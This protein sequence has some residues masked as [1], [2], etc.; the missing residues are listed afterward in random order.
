MQAA[1]N[2][3]ASDKMPTAVSA[4]GKVLLAGG[5]LVLDRK[6]TGL[7]FG[8]SARIHVLVSE[9]NAGNL[10]TVRS[11]QFVDAIWVYNY[12]L[13]EGRGVQISQV[14][15]GVDRPASPNRFVE[16]SLT[17]GLT[18]I[19]ALDYGSTKI[20]PLE[21]TILADTDYYSNTPEPS[22]IYPRF[23]FF[24]VPLTSAH[25]TGLGS[26][27]ALVTA[28]TT[29]ILLHFIPT[30]DLC[31]PM[32][33]T[34]IHN[35]AQIVHCAAQKKVGSGFDVAAAVYGACI[36][37]RFSPSV[38]EGVSESDS[39]D[40]AARLHSIVENPKS[41]DVEI[42]R[43]DAILPTGWALFMCDVD[44]GSSTISMVKNVLKWRE[45]NSNIAD[46][47]WEELQQ[48]QEDLVAQLKVANPQGVKQSF[49]KIRHQIRQLSMLSGVPIEPPEQ[50]A[51]LDAINTNVEE[52]I[53]GVV[54][55]A[56]G[57]DAAVLLVRENKSVT[58]KL[59]KF[60]E[61]WSVQKGGKFR[62]LGV[63][64]ESGG[65]RMEKYENYSKRV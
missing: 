19:T 9:S 26:S 31:I 53:S 22:Q 41:W 51:L 64:G 50:T 3:T 58:V 4:P 14:V 23:P 62:L 55:G 54:P 39:A 60:L 35:L 37:R 42:L 2:G 21:I 48:L 7:V 8:L 63:R 38:L 27:A 18:Y 5:Y 16:T 13:A 15:D 43:D 12:S 44:C 32:N 1:E 29:A 36:Y 11:P 40:F 10:I 61:S 45:D 57:Y 65:V 52:V 6:Y 17:Y 28:L 24:N 33:R 46:L 34:K 47:I 56:G 30:F 25:K 59:T 49:E 20:V